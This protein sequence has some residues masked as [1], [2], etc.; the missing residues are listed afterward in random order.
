MQTLV[1]YA[2]APGKPIR[3]TGDF[4]EYCRRIPPDPHQIDAQLR[5]FKNRPTSYDTRRGG[6][7]Q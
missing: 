4:V 6:F 5:R 1:I 7:G 2:A 3:T